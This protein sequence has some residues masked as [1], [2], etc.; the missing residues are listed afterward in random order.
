MLSLLLL[1]Q[2][3][4]LSQN[5]EGY[6]IEVIGKSPRNMQT[7]TL[8]LL[9][10]EQTLVDYI[11]KSSEVKIPHRH[12]HTRLFNYTSFF[13]SKIPKYYLPKEC[14]NPDCIDWNLKVSLHR[15][16][17]DSYHQLFKQKKKLKNGQVK[18]FHI[19]KVSITIDTLGDIKD[20]RQKGFDIEFFYIGDGKGPVPNIS[21][22]NVLLRWI[23]NQ[24][25]LTEEDIAELGL[26]E[27][28]EPMCEI[29]ANNEFHP[30]TPSSLKKGKKIGRFKRKANFKCLCNSQI[31][32]NR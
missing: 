4:T 5:F 3:K 11:K 10:D 17:Y 15:S 13:F 31:P 9:M 19:K 1:I 28:L 23:H 21:E 6:Y 27:Y 30:N 20:L 14:D 7:T 26:S 18:A 12:Y 22:N 29:E 24:T 25:V 2:I 16:N 8:E 32:S